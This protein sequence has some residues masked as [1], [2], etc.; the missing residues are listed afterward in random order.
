M[1]PFDRQRDVSVFN[2]T[3]QFVEFHLDLTGRAFDRVD[4]DCI[5]YEST[6]SPPRLPH[7]AYGDDSSVTTKTWKI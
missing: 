5:C 7:D 1:D 3:I 4:F 2:S 6:F